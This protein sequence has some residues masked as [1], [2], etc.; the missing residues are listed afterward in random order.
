MNLFNA[1]IVVFVAVNNLNESIQLIS[2]LQLPSSEISRRSAITT[3][4]TA[5][6]AA[7]VTGS[8]PSICVAK[9]SV[10]GPSVVLNSNN[11]KHFPLA[12][13]GLQIYNDDTAYKLTLTALEV[14]YRNFFASVLA[15]NQKGFAK[16]RGCHL[17]NLSIYQVK[18]L[19]ILVQLYNSHT[20]L[21]TYRQSKHP[22]FLVTNSTFGKASLFSFFEGH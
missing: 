5:S 19:M 16:V 7:V 6:S 9:G 15:G 13:F 14:G 8:M 10:G 21:G 2:A 3:I 17:I 18:V 22:A 12:S 4:T 20:A 11:K 1:A